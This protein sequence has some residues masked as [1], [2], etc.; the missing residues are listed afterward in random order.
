MDIAKEMGKSVGVVT[1]DQIYGAT[2]SG[3]SAHSD[4]RNN[5][6]LITATQLRSGVD[7][8]C[9]L[10]NDKYYSEYQ[11]TIKNNGYH[12]AT[13]FNDKKS[14]MNAEKVFLPVDIENGSKNEIALKD[15]ASLAIEFLERDEDGF[16][17]MIEQAYIDKYS[18]NNDIDGMLDRMSSLNE[19]VDTVVDWMG[20]RKDTAVIVT[21]D[22]ETGGLKASATTN[23]KNK[24]T[25]GEKTFYYEWSSTGHTQTLVKIYVYGYDVDFKEIS[26]YGRKD[27]LKNTDVFKLMKRIL[28]ENK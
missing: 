28:D 6:A 2:P 7:L 10:R 27:A 8:F 21:A 26:E 23:Y 25:K 1:S 22:H 3:F 9:G 19:T 13:S 14:I 24:Y 16:V 18:H 17:L 5:S 15:A 4:D 20:D 12:Y 11:V